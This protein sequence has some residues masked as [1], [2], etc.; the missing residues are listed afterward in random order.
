MWTTMALLLDDC[1]TFGF[2]LEMK[3]VAVMIQTASRQDIGGE[4]RQQ[5]GA[6]ERLQGSR[7]I[8]ANSFGSRHSVAEYG[9]ENRPA[10]EF[11]RGHP[12]LPG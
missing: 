2:L 7:G 11:P 9:R 8:S 1:T 12:R 3:H 4:G 6:P 5:F 10:T